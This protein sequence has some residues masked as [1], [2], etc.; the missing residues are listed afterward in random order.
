[1]EKAI[2]ILERLRYNGLKIPQI[3]D[4]IKK[5]VL[6]RLDYTMMNSVISKVELTGLD[7]FVRNITND[8]GGDSSL[9]KN[10]FY[11][12]SKNDG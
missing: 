9:S 11:T 6:L 5:F 4:A 1:M 12:S 7:K 10:L 2:N 8:L 3:T